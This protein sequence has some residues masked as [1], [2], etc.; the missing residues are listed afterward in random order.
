MHS[1]AEIVEKL[2]THTFLFSWP[3]VIKSF[4]TKYPNPHMSYVKFNNV[5]DME[6]IDSEKIKIKRLMF[7]KLTVL[8]MYSIEDIIINLKEKS[9]EFSTSMLK[10]SKVFPFGEENC[11]YAAATIDGIERTIYTKKMLSNAKILKFMDYF[12]K[13][14]LKGCQTIEEKCKILEEQEKKN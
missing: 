12:N 8:I 3:T 1:P 2:D 6:I 11:K 5:I 10:K 14:F 4:W 13:S 9:M 7:S